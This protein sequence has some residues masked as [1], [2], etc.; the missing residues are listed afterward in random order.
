MFGSGMA[1]GAS[2]VVYVFVCDKKIPRVKGKSSIVYIGQ[3]KQNL[4]TRY[5][6]YANAFCSVGNWPFFSYIIKH[7]GT[8][9]IAYLRVQDL[10][11]AET[12]LLNDYYKKFKEYPPHNFQRR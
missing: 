3:T 4:S 11:Q 7:Y 9:G 1:K 5:M 6:R 10:K 12:D 8:T 2:G